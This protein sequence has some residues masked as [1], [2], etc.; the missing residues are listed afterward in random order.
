M[1][2]IGNESIAIN[3][4]WLG[5]VEAALKRPIFA[6]AVSKEI[7][8]GTLA[9][10]MALNDAGPSYRR[11]DMKRDLHHPNCIECKWLDNVVMV[12]KPALLN[13]GFAMILDYMARQIMHACI[14]ID[15]WLSKYL[16]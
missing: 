13:Q 16:Q 14:F 6:K 12:G 10:T 11:I 7:Y 4:S 15:K 2:A 1:L 9:K 5:K 3:I 8:V